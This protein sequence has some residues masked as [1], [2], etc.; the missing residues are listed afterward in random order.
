MRIAGT[1]VRARVGASV[2]LRLTHDVHPRAGE[3]APQVFTLRYAAPEV[4][5][6]EAAGASALVATGAQDVWALGIVAYE[7]LTGQ[8]AFDEVAPER[9]VQ[10]ALLG[11]APLPWERPGAAAGLRR[12]RGL[13][14]SVLQCL[15]RE[16]GERPSSEELLGLWNGLFEGMTGTTSDRFEPSTASGSPVAPPW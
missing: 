9:E 10:A 2:C 5:A 15:A 6:A 4:I 13:R 7:L 11:G 1:A 3:I 16:P 12:L 8:L 14:R